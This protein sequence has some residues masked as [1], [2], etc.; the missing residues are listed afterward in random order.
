MADTIKREV[1]TVTLTYEMAVNIDTGEILETKLIKRTVDNVKKSSKKVIVDNGEPKLYLEDNKYRLNDT[2]IAL[3]NL[4]E[5]S[6]LCIRYEQGKNGDWPVIGTN[7]SFGIASG[8]KISKSNTVACRGNNH[9][10]LARHGSEFKLVPHPDRPG[11]FILD[12]GN[13]QNLKGDEN[14]QVNNEIEDLNFGIEDLV[15]DVDNTTEIDS[16]F[17]KL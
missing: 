7:I 3:L 17:F 14:I 8:N 2:A 4:D 9:S 10:E 15:E 5:D 16:N 12:S 1:F 11:I 6:K 13:I